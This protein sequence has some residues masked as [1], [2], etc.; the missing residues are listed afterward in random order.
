MKYPLSTNIPFPFRTATI[1]LK[2]FYMIYR[3]RLNDAYLKGLIDFFHLS[4]N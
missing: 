2:K 3:P 4:F 1:L